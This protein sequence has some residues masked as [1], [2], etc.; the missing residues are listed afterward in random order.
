MKNL[1]LVWICVLV[2]LSSSAWAQSDGNLFVGSRPLAMG[3]AFTAVADDANAMFYN[4]A[5]LQQLRQHEVSFMNADLFGTGIRTT[6]AVYSFPI[7]LNQAVGIDWQH[8]GFGDGELGYN[9]DVIKVAF[10]RRLL[11]KLSVGAGVKYLLTDMSL[12]GQSV[13][14]GSGLGVDLGAMYAV[15]PGLKIGIGA[16]DVS[17]TKVQYQDGGSATLLPLLFRG[18]VAWQARQ[19]LLVAA[20][21]DRKLHIGSEYRLRNE[22]VLRGGFQKDLKTSDP[23]EMNFGIG[24]NYKS[25]RFDFTHSPGRRG[26]GQTQRYGFS[27][28]FD[29]ASSA[30]RIIRVEGQ[31]LFASYY[32]TYE[33]QD[34]GS[35]LLQNKSDKSLECRLTV[36]LPGY[37]EVPY[38]ET[39]IVRKGG[40]AQEVPLRI[41]LSRDVLS[42]AKDVAIPVEVKVEYSTGTKKRSDKQS[43]K[44]VLYG[45]GALLWDDIGRAAAFVTSRDP[46][47]EAFARHVSHQVS[48]YAKIRRMERNIVQA[49]AVF[50]ALRTY[51]IKYQIDPN[52]P[53]AQVVDADWP[54]DNIQYPR[55]LL[56]K[57]TGDCDDCTVLYCSLLENLGIATAVVDVPGHIFA[58]FDVGIDP[59]DRYRLGIPEHKMVSFKGKL[60]IPVETTLWGKPFEEVWEAGLEQLRSVENLDNHV[61]MVSESWLKYPPS[62]P[63]FEFEIG[64]EVVGATCDSTDVAIRKNMLDGTKREFVIQ[65]YASQLASRTDD[66]EL[67]FELAYVYRSM[68]MAEDAR[69]HARRAV[70]LSGNLAEAETCLGN[71]YFVEGN[72]KQ[73]VE[74]Y[75]R[76]TEIDPNDPGLKANLQRAMRKLLEEEGKRVR[77]E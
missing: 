24:L 70:E 77:K 47:V 8:I 20:D 64:Q 31:D 6:Y 67:Q 54:F 14:K 26:L 68:N 56:K 44:L 10:A 62:D 7:S 32:R 23:L 49:G 34:V 3:G 4:P 29:P 19:E 40:K 51:G 52:N 58:M 41:S 9:R 28:S 39:V 72:L 45:R 5:G 61:R 60:W 22:L 12:D 48:S 57:W 42:L 21:L 59:V 18:G 75:Q 36:S 38:Q 17:G 74:H 27:A 35:I 71:S 55:E 11:P 37:E 53:Y 50:E 73:A 15:R 69:T 76:A 30:V 1:M 16:H 33:G 63:P 66:S 2:I 13:G 25:F 46:E 43:A 65:E